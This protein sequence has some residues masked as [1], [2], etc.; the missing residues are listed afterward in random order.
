M[1]TFAP[2]SH[3]VTILDWVCSNSEIVLLPLLVVLIVRYKMF[4]QLKF[5]VLYIFF[6]IVREI[7]LAWYGQAPA[8]GDP[9]F[10]PYIYFYWTAAF[11]ISFLRLF[12][13]LEICEKVLRRYPALRE[14]A[15]RIMAVLGVALFSWTLYVTIHNFHHLKKFI[16]TFQQTT[17]ISFALLLLTLLGIG[18][19]YRMRIPPLYLAILIGSGIYSAIQAVD[20]ELGRQTV[21]LPNSVFDFAQRL[22]Y[23]LMLTIWAWAIWRWGKDTAPP[24]ELLSQATYDDLSPQVHD[25]LKELNDKLSDLASKRRH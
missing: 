16:L 21:N 9:A 6:T 12:I 15:W 25:R 7:A 1:V 10:Y 18:A 24:P 23:M 5:F 3:L 4:S 20:S 22:T 11:T 17:D 13:T 8:I 19:Y 14:F 2:V